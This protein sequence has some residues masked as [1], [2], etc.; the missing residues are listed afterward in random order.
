MSRVA[1]NHPITTM[2]QLHLSMAT[3]NS[4]FAELSLADRVALYLPHV[5]YSLPLPPQF[6]A[7]ALTVV[8]AT[9]LVIAGSYATVSQPKTAEDPCDD[10]ESPLWDVTDRDDCP[11]YF[12]CADDILGVDSDVL[13]AKS[14]AALV[15]AAAAALKALD[16]VLRHFGVSVLRFLNYYVVAVTLFSGTVTLQW[17]LGVLLR[18]VAYA[19]GLPGNLSF[20]FGRLRLSVAREDRLPLGMAEDMDEQKLD[21]EL[22]DFQAYEH[23]MRR[24][25]GVR[26]LRPQQSHRTTSVVVDGRLAVA[27]PAAVA[28]LA[29][30][31]A[32]NA[33]L[34][35]YGLPRLNWLINNAVA[36][37]LA[38]CGCRQIRAGT[39]RT[40]LLLLAA[41]F[42][43]DVYFVFGSTAMEAVA[44][45]VDAPLRLVF[46]QRPAALLSWA[47]A[48]LCTFKDL[49]GPATILGLG[50]IVV[51]SVLSSLCLRY[52][53]AQFYRQRAPL[54]FH[55]LR[56]VGTPVYFCASVAAYAA[57]V[58]TTIAASQ[59]SRRGQ[60]ALL[61]I[62]PMMGG[63]IL[64]TAWWRGETEGL[65][66]YSEEMVPYEGAT[67]DATEGSAG[68]CLQDGASVQAGTIYEFD[69]NETD[70]TYV[71]EDDT[72]D[73]EDTDDNDTDNDT[74]T[75]D[76]T[77]L[78]L[79]IHTLLLDLMG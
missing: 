55:R 78:G 50:D 67:E 23:W 60:P 72:A 21:A 20:F 42:V 49:D 13:G 6:V 25:N 10:T 47:Q 40:A 30:F 26:V 29:L 19:C 70:D 44:A 69:D 11:L 48:Q 3:V 17:F 22:G 31:Y 52:D 33:Q 62:V 32:H 12:T 46:P 65:A 37:V 66:A 24:H 41:L 63:A 16:Y 28:L 2:S 43:Y 51:P 14:V 1:P 9:A 27:F 74:D 36:G 54:A 15:V 4:T 58:G 79:E 39:F 61:Y 35:S 34:S 57:A 56:S 5:I 64:G 75:D 73:D 7:A 8:S 38:V 53:I 45:G 76:N 77:N 18:N 71:I 68:G 59:W